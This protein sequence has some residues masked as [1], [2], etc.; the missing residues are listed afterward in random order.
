MPHTPFNIWAYVDGWTMRA[1]AGFL[2]TPGETVKAPDLKLVRGGF[3]TGVVIDGVTGKRV[4]PGKGSDVGLYGPSRPR[5]GAAIESAKIE[6]DGSFRIRAAPG[7]NYVYLRSRDAGWS[8]AEAHDVEV[9]EG[10]VVAVKF[11][12]WRKE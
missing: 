10:E 8:R 4:Q 12:V 2:V 1:H 7:A 9:K 6:S 5:P 3:I 11:V